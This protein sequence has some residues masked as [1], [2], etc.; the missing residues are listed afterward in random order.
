MSKRQSIK[1][2]PKDK[3]INVTAVIVTYNRVELLQESINA[4]LAQQGDFLNHVYVVNNASTD[5]TQD[6][7]ESF[8]DPKVTVK[9]LNENIGG[10]GGFNL[11]VRFFIEKTTDHYVWLMDDDTIPSP[12]ALQELIDFYENHSEASF[13]S[14]NVRWQTIGGEPSYMN[15]PR[16]VD[17][18]EEGQPISSTINPTPQIANATFVSTMFDRRTVLEI[19]LPQKEYFI[20]G[21]DIEYTNRAGRIGQGFLILD[22]LVAH[23][24]KENTHAGDIVNEEDHNRLSRYKY[25]MRNRLLTGRRTH[26]L[27][28]SGTARNGIDFLK[29]LFKPD[30]KFRFKKLGIIFKGTIKGWFFR[31]TIEHP[32][33]ATIAH[34]QK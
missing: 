22:S 34:K 21:D 15:V 31:P 12:T 32:K 29:V 10:A 11:G 23:K 14:S 26:S 16:Q 19:G 24:S 30:V 6:F 9:N 4:V 17:R 33:S 7:L 2:T 20:W 1:E 13:V 25:E 8:N 18:K 5:N 27:A 3:K 28:H